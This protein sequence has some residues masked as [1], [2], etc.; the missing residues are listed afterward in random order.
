MRGDDA[1]CVSMDVLTMRT[2]NA[3]VAN[4]TSS[5]SANIRATG[6]AVAVLRS[7]SKSSV[8]LASSSASTPSSLVRDGRGWGGT[9]AMLP[10]LPLDVPS[11]IHMKKEKEN[12]N[13]TF[14]RWLRLIR[15][16]VQR[17]LSIMARTF[18]YSL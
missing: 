11:M 15:V 5:A 16:G 14:H 1:G 17:V 4:A 3:V 18:K 10:L 6:C 13:S 2:A 8:S 12:R 9:R 7:C